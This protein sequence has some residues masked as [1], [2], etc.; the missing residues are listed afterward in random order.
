MERNA[1]PIAG[2]AAI[3]LVAAVLTVMTV[4]GVKGPWQSADVEAWTLTQGDD[5]PLPTPTPEYWAFLPLALKHRAAEEPPATETATPTPTS[6]PTATPT[7]TPTPTP[8]STPIPDTVRVL[9]NHTHYVDGEG[10]LHI[11]GEVENGTDDPVYRVGLTV[12]LLSSDGDVVDTGHG[13]APLQHL[14]AGE[15]TCFHISVQDPADWSS[16]AFESPSYSAGPP[17]P[18]LS[19]VND[20]GAYVPAAGWY[21]LGG[22]VHNDHGARVKEVIAVG[23]LYDGGGDPVGCQG[24]YVLSIGLDPGEASLF[25]MRFAGR[26]F[27]DVVDHRVQVDGDPE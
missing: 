7:A 24:A 8:T 9:L 6:T 3:L 14:A 27:G 13:V 18:A 10:A 1:L 15:R 22:E 12:Q 2:I 20:S 21:L 11:V 16:Y 5:S 4:T 26:D 19:V 25:E 23:T 17:P